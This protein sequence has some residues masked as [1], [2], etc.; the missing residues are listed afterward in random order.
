M[1]G[2]EL[3]RK[4]PPSMKVN[5]FAADCSQTNAAKQENVAPNPTTRLLTRPPGIRRTPSAAYASFPFDQTARAQS[6]PL[7]PIEQ[8]D[9]NA[10]AR[11]GHSIGKSLSA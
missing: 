5:T 9:S 3:L 8:S 6:G 2:Q 4:L 7:L 11:V 10:P 1:Q